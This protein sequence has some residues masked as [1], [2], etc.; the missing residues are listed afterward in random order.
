MFITMIRRRVIIVFTH[1]LMVIILALPLY[2]SPHPSPEPQISES[3]GYNGN[4]I[5]LER[6]SGPNQSHTSSGPV[7]YTI[8]YIQDMVGD[9]ILFSNP[10]ITDNI[11]PPESITSQLQ[12]SHSDNNT[13]LD[14]NATHINTRIIHPSSPRSAKSMI[15]VANASNTSSVTTPN[16]ICDGINDHETIQEAIDN[17][18]ASGGTIAL[19]EGTY[20]IKDSI[21]LTDNITI[22]G[23]PGRTVFDCSQISDS[24]FTFSNDDGYSHN[25]TNITENIT[26]GSQ[27]VMVEDVSAY[28]VG[29]Y[30]KLSDDS[31]IGVFRK[32]ELLR[33]VSI[34]YQVNRLTVEHEIIHDYNRDNNALIRRLTM[35]ENIS[36]CGIDFNGPG[37][38]TDQCLARAYLQRNFQVTDCKVKD[39]G[40]T[41]FGLT[42]CLDSEFKQNQF[43]NVFR[44]GFGYSIALLNACQNIT[45]KNN[46]FTKLGRHY[47][48]ISSSTG[49]YLYGG[50]ARDITITNNYFEN[51]SEEAINSHDPCF[52]PIEIS[53]NTFISCGKGIDLI[54]ANCV[55]TD[56][57]FKDCPIAVRLQGTEERSSDIIANIFEDCTPYAIKIN[58]DNVTVSGNIIR[59]DGRI[60]PNANNLL[61]EGNSFMD[62]PPT[63]GQPIY[64]GGDTEITYHNWELSG[65]IFL[66]CQVNSVIKVMYIDSVIIEDNFSLRSGM[67]YIQHSTNTIIRNNVSI[68]CMDGI[69]CH[70]VLDTMLI[71]TNVVIG[72]PGIPLMID[73]ST[74]PDAAIT[75]QDNIFDGKLP[76][77][78]DAEAKNISWINNKSSVWSEQS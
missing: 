64:G 42:D 8:S 69:R 36:I 60:Q 39:F 19:L 21:T 43:E 59:G 26:S 46:R 73:G 61:I 71:S 10:Q 22:Q 78:L 6:E 55:I 41:A 63:S 16:Y 33:I 68:D 52:G 37:I 57:H 76:I 28:S 50:W 15:I 77:R 7:L 70:N 1:I 40:I 72:T 48:V 30:V 54:N 2:D 65:N 29:D 45:I 4:I 20:I 11:S 23:I 34:D 25:P 17:L 14:N 13:V 38:E 56:N 67:I 53:S 58:T 31:S 12:T 62:Y 75:V 24:V 5:R 66:D 47:L 27:T 9:T 51:S 3:P 74:V 49:T 35:C 18:P 44:K 32:G